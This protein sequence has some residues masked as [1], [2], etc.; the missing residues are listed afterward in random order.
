[1]YCAPPLS[2]YLE[3]T[4]C[5]RTNAQND[6]LLHKLVHTQLLS[7]SLNADLNLT[8]AQRRKALEGRVMELAGDSSLGKG[9]KLIREAERNKM[10]KRVREGMIFKQKERDA[11][12]LQE[13]GVHFG[14]ITFSAAELSRPG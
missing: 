3:L 4:A 6:A 11:K 13:V 14:I 10:S 2:I 12:T 9:E 1:L 7:G 8:P 5:F